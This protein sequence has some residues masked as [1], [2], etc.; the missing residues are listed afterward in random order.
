MVE[1]ND[2]R[3]SQAKDSLLELTNKIAPGTVLKLKPGQFLDANTAFSSGLTPAQFRAKSLQPQLQPD[4]EGSTTTLKR[5]SS[6]QQ[7]FTPPTTNGPIKIEI[8]DLFSEQ[9]REILQRLANGEREL[10]IKASFGSRTIAAKKF[11]ELQR[12]AKKGLQIEPGFDVMRIS[13]SQAVRAGVI[14]VKPLQLDINT[15]PER[16]QNVLLLLSNG[17]KPNQIRKMLHMPDSELAT[18]TQTYARSCRTKTHQE[19][20][21]RLALTIPPTLD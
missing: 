15:I 9:E 14:E 21:A 17:Y 10:D 3:R 20:L 5:E 11:Q 18:I 8:S 19:F 6:M 4:I 1:H 13:L 7:D 12:K 16:H 2:S